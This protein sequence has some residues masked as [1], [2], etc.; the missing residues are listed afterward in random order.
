MRVQ[1]GLK[2]GDWRHWGE[3]TTFKQNAAELLRKALRPHQ[4]I[5]CSPLTDPYQPAETD[6]AMM[7]DILREVAA[8]PPRAFI[9]QTRGPLIL[10][11]IPLLL[12]ARA[13][14]SFS[15]T[16]DRDD[17]RRIFEP[18]CAPISERWNTVEALENAGIPT[19]ITLAPLLPCDPE[20]LMGRALAATSGPVI[21]D[22]F[23][24]RAVKRSGATTR[25]PAVAICH[26]LGY[27]EWI[28][29]GFQRAI[30]AR[31]AQTASVAGRPFGFGT[32][33]FSL[34]TGQSPGT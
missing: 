7:P 32:A 22:P 9:I 14:V 10:R 25:E 21:A 28:D 8:N 27:S 16:T 5:Y 4:I 6:G 24:V 26:K 13:R 20:E 19:A 17:I 23:H 33:G 30:L 15:I 31:L 12:A 2:P 3:F 11:D 34:L 18:H 29:P 1:G